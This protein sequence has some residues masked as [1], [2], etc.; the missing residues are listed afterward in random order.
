MF[1][2]LVEDVGRVAAVSRAGAGARLRVETALPAA[3]LS[4]GASV[5]V[6]GPCLTVTSSGSGFFE[7]D[8]SA[9]TLR[10]TTLGGLRPGARVNLERALA[11]GGRLGG[12]FVLGHVDGIC[13]VAEA[14][15]SGAYT[16]LTFSADA[17]LM[18]YMVPKG[19][20]AV[21]GVSLTVN[22]AGGGRFTVMVIPHTLGKTTLAELTPGARVNVECDVL[23]KYVA[24]MLGR[25]GHGGLTVDDLAKAGFVDGGHGQ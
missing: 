8:V 10:V 1:T 11:A 25:A 24:A 7:A 17:A 5:A 18:K 22:A 13:R 2:G 15:R 4:I 20:V 6:G 19:S 3:D 16:A 23:G 14:G 9:E 12:H 21:D